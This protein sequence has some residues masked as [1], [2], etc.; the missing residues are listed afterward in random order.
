VCALAVLLICELAARAVALHLPPPGGWYSR[1]VQA[2]VA[3]ME[4]LEANG[5]TCL[6]FVGSSTVGAAIAPEVL[7]STLGRDDWYVAWVAGANARVLNPW[8]E[9]I[10]VSKLAPQFV[11]IGVTSFELNDAYSAES[12]LDSYIESPGRHEAIGSIGLRDRISDA[13]TEVSAFFELRPYLR[14]PAEFVARLTGRIPSMAPE[15]GQFDGARNTGYAEEPDGMARVRAYV[16]TFSLGERTTS[17]LERTIE[18][19]RAQ[20]RTVALVALAVLESEWASW[21][22]HGMADI[23]AYRESLAAIGER[24]NV[25]LFAYPGELQDE[26][27]YRDPIHLNGEGSSLFTAR[28]GED[29]GQ[30]MRDSGATCGGG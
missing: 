11:V 3:R 22:E 18:E 16:D 29:L 25:P 8:T 21:H 4:E 19:L 23:E 17:A 5:E 15:H 7:T 14:S 9:E 13:M 6:A 26:S 27:L 1:E 30:W 20:G 28:L 2:Q 10:V 24:H 12:V